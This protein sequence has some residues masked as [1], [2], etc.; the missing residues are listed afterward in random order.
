MRRK[1]QG[2]GRVS[3][4]SRAAQWALQS[5]SYSASAQTQRVS[6]TVGVRDVTVHRRKPAA[7]TLTTRFS[8][9]ICGTKEPQVPRFKGTSR[10]SRTLGSQPPCHFAEAPPHLLPTLQG[11]EGKPGPGRAAFGLSLCSF[12]LSGDLA[13]LDTQ[14]GGHADLV[15]GSRQPPVTIRQG[16]HLLSADPGATS[17]LPTQPGLQARS[18]AHEA[19]QGA[20]LDRPTRAQARKLPD[21]RS[22]LPSPTARSMKRLVK[23]PPGLISVIPCGPGD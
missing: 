21:S 2:T 8:P 4:R 11:P 13:H 23:G 15:L 12:V 17:L 5:L 20:A 6:S 3:G 14:P 18:P 7:G 16:P 1:S 22:F 9:P 19:E 10:L